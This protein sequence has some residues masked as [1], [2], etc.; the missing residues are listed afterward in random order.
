MKKRIFVL[1]S[2]TLVFLLVLSGCGECKHEWQEADCL[3]AKICTKCQVVEGEALGHAWRAATCDV[4]ETCARCGETQGEK[5]EHVYGKWVIGETD[6]SR[7]CQN[8]EAVESAE[9]DRELYLKQVLSGHWDFYALRD[10]EEYIY[11]YELKDDFQLNNLH[12][13][14]ENGSW[15]CNGESRFEITIE[16]DEY[17]YADGSE[18]YYFYVVF[19]DDGSKQMLVY[20]ADMDGVTLP[21]DGAFYILERNQ[22]LHDLMTGLWAE[23]EGEKISVLELKDDRTFTAE[24]AG[25]VYTGTWHLRGQN[26]YR[27]G[28]DSE[29]VYAQAGLDLIYEKDGQTVVKSH[30]LSL[31]ERG[32]D[33]QDNLPYYGFSLRLTDDYASVAKMS[34]ENLEKL[35]EANETGKKLI[36]G[37]WSSIS[38]SV[39]AKA[40]SAGTKKAAMDYTVTFHEDGTLTAS[41][42]KAYTGTWKF[43][44][45][46][47][48]GDSVSYYYDMEVDGVS[49]YVYAYIDYDGE[50]SI[51]GSDDNASYTVYLKQMTQEEKDQLAAE[52]EKAKTAILG[53]WT[54]YSI[55]QDENMF[56][57]TGYTVTFRDDGTFTTNL[58]EGSTGSWELETVDVMDELNIFYRYKLTIDGYSGRVNTYLR[59]GEDLTIGLYGDSTSRNIDFDQFTAEELARIEDA[60]K[61]IVGTWTGKELTWYNPETQKRETL[62]KETH[63]ITVNEDGTFTSTLPGMT[64]GTWTFWRIEDSE[65]CYW[66][67]KPDGYTNILWLNQEGVLEAG[68]EEGDKYLNVNLTK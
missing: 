20:M 24:I 35:K 53:D 58:E 18:L 61:V 43:D 19:V 55:N 6:M 1:L 32:E 48:T 57:D 52:N 25:E 2:L 59:V 3:N 10:G 64:S 17:D 4:P 30:N 36:L 68:F 34:P 66:F 50:L 46:S 23:V 16:F 65:N 9:I 38:T 45:A 15:W 44:E 31:G 63:T 40:T 39:Y 22:E 12:V 26:Y 56:S 41:M 14:F 7:T 42:D 8:C 21:Y 47:L 28:Y 60:P 62:R 33:L 27:T 5:L 49:S 51:H 29:T 11:S 13:D 67:Q 54:S 37:E